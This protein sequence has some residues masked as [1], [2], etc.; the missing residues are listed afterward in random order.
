MTNSTTSKGWLRKTNFSE[1]KEDPIQVT[2][3]LEVARIHAM[4]YITLGIR[5][6][7]QWFLDSRAICHSTPAQQNHLMADCIAALVARETA[8][9]G[10]THKD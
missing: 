10:K 8:V 2:V 3:R 6:Y 7:S 9:T 1:L 4:H 5:E